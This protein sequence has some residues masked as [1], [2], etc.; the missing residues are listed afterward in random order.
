MPRS[1]RYYLSKKNPDKDK[2]LAKQVD[3]IYTK[4]P[5]YGSR[6]IRAVLAR[7]G[8]C[9][10]RK[11]LRA[12]MTKIGIAGNQPGPATSKSH[13][14]HL[15]LPYLLRDVKI[16]RPMQVWSTDI[17]YIRTQKGFAYLLAVIDWP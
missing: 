3:G 10:N 17:T 12:P 7:E 1:S 11:R 9:V 14:E 4:H 13:P 15:K 6:R 5:Y 16:T 2:G 8:V